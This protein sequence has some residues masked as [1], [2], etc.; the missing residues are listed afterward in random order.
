MTR[1]GGFLEVFKYAVK[2]ADQEPADTV[3]AFQVLKGRRLLDSAG[4][5]RGVEVP[6]ELTDEPLD[7]LPYVE[8]FYRFL[9]AGYGLSRGCQAA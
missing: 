8:L 3:H 9:G 6:Q 1:R 2:F 5:F 4:A 7:G